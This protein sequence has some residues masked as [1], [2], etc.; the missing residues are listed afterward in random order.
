MLG[1]P[2]KYS[3]QSTICSSTLGPAILPS[4]LICPTTKTVMP[5]DLE[6]C[7]RVMVQSFTWEMLPGEDS[8]FSLYKV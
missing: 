5:W 8:L 1:S 6:I 7:I 2:S 4:L 3:T